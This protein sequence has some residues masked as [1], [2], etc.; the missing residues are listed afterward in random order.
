MVAPRFIA[1]SD[2]AALQV[3]P[4]GG[5]LLP[6]SL[7]DRFGQELN[8]RDFGA[9]GS[10]QATT[11]AMSAGSKVVTLISARDF[12]NGQ[13]IAV[14]GAGPQATVQQPTGLTLS[15][16]GTAGSTTHTYS[17]SS[18][19]AL[20]GVGAAIAGVDIT[21]ANASLDLNN[22]VALTW[23]AP[24]SG[25]L[26]KGYVIYK[27]GAFI[28]IASNA[29]A[30]NDMGVVRN[31]PSW[32]PSTPPGSATSSVLVSS[33]VS[34]GGTTSLTLQDAAST[35]VSTASVKHDDTAAV[36]LA[37][38]MAVGTR[39]LHIPDGT[40]II[41]STINITATGDLDVFCTRNATLKSSD[42]LGDQIFGFEDFTARNRYA[43]SWRGGK[44]DNSA[45]M[46]GIA[47][48]SDSCVG[49]TRI[50]NMLFDGVL[51]QGATSQALA[52][53]TT[54]SGIA[55]VDSTNVIITNC[56]FIGQGDLGIYGSGGGLQ[57]GADDGGSI[58][59]TNNVFVNCGVGV[60][61]KRQLPRSIVSNNTFDGCFVG[62]ALLEASVG[63][64]IDPGR[65]ALISNNII[66]KTICCGICV[67]DGAADTDDGS[68]TGLVRQSRTQILN[69]KIL[70]FGYLADG[71]TP[72]A[73]SAAF[74][75]TISGI[76]LQGA[77]QCR[78][79]GNMIALEDWTQGGNGS[80][81][82]KAIFIKSFTL[83][84][85][86]YNPDKTLITNCDFIN[87]Y[88]GIVE[89]AGSP[90]V[91]PTMGLVLSFTNV[92][93]FVSFVNPLSQYQWLDF[94]NGFVRHTVGGAEVVRLSSGGIFATR[95]RNFSDTV[96]FTKISR[97][98]ATLN[99]GSIPANGCVDLTV[100]ITGLTVAS[101]LA[102][103]NPQA[104]NLYAAG[105]SYSCF[106]S[107]DDTVTV[108]ALNLT[109]SPITVPSGSFVVNGINIS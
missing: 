66:R 4:T 35:S 55:F 46:M 38:Q 30:F 61:L 101:G 15:T 2:I 32:C 93:S 108:R 45:G 24:A 96:G 7:S 92:H 57:S 78:L 41:S 68:G 76:C 11:G 77:S 14:Y 21:T 98:V 47:V 82:H 70:D 91:G 49:I 37:F 109:T 36:L 95:F 59:I 105:I 83:N 50:S 54:D 20:G 27:D 28:S 75:G 79:D 12:A 65:Q 8:V 42:F 34:G 87:V 1:A 100:T 67:H 107:A 43:L 17:V 51:F 56:M 3:P 5:G 22:Y 73:G 48:A 104:T 52:S 53:V 31:C 26:P 16:N 90:S 71:V 13:G 88:F 106:V 60:G 62:V 39:R 33:I 19:N 74:G 69:N 10:A 9:S 97:A 23:V 86:V 29:T 80:T 18:I 103:A 94:A 25:P 99:F 44:F 6:I 85:V 72:Y 64:A 89:D 84:S 63:P 58:I 102:F 81:S 40:Y